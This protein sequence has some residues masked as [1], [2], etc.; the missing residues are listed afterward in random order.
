MNQQ[1]HL[2]V[3]YIELDNSFYMLTVYV[4]GKSRPPHEI[5]Y[6]SATRIRKKYKSGFY[7]IYRIVKLHIRCTVSTQTTFVYKLKVVHTHLTNMRKRGPQ[8][9]V[10]QLTAMRCLAM[11]AQPQILRDMDIDPALLNHPAATVLDNK[12]M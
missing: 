7:S 3:V 10:T 9:V 12:I 6:C 2:V 5:C 4:T 11:R 1:I 8:N